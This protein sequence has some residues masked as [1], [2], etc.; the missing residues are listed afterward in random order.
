MSLMLIDFFFTFQD[1]SV[2]TLIMTDHFARDTRQ[3]LRQLFFLL[4]RYA[5]I[6]FEEES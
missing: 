5:Q 4:K 1:I 2:R 6:T 3:G